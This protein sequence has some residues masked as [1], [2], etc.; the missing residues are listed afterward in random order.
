MWESGRRERR[1]RRCDEQ[2]AVVRVKE[3]R[4]E[5]WRGAWRGREEQVARWVMCVLPPNSILI[6]N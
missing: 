5:S 1:R 4:E 3:G 6:A 2:K